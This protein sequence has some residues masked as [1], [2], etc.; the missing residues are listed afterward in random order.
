MIGRTNAG[1]GGG[2]LNFRVIGGTTQPTSPKENDIWVNTSTNIPQWIMSPIDPLEANILSGL[3][4]GD[5]YLTGSA[6]AGPT[7]ANPELHTLSYIPVDPKKSY[8]C[9]ITCSASNNLWLAV[10]E[11]DANKNAKQRVMPIYVTAS[12]SEGV[13]TPTEGTVYARV[14]WRTF[15]GA[16]TK[17]V[18]R[19][20]PTEGT[21]WI[22]TS[23]DDGLSFNAL[24]KNGLYVCPVS[25]KQYI[26]SEWADLEAYA[27]QGG[28]WVQFSSVAPPY[29]YKDGETSVN[30]LGDGTNSDGYLTLTS[31]S[32]SRT[33]EAY[34][35]IPDIEKYSTISCVIS[36]YSGFTPM[37][38]IRQI[39]TGTNVATAKPSAQGETVSV[40]LSGLGL[41]GNDYCFVLHT[42]AVWTSTGSTNGYWSYGTVKTNHI[43]GA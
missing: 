32:D 10:M 7:A 29:F 1:G 14:T 39:S 15:P 11:Y 9:K 41:S 37:V 23:S 26:D 18:F 43:W 38:Y 21:L 28:E 42:E 35:V 22:Q 25:C 6:V 24:K 19:E 40:D 2:G 36:S 34:F 4:T 17:A 3:P 30:L 13:Y 16:T 33:P 20:I 8:H 31:T 5:G 27:C 12:E